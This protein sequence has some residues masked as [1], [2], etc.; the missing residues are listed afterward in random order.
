MWTQGAGEPTALLSRLLE[1]R[2]AIGKFRM[3]LGAGYASTVRPEHADVISFVGLGAV[4]SNAAMCRAGLVDILPCHL[5]EVPVMLRNDTLHVDVV[6]MQLSS[7]KG[8]FSF[9]ATN[10]YVQAALASA[11]VVMA[12]VNDKAPW[13]YS[14]DQFDDSCLSACVPHSQVMMQLPPKAIDD[15]D[16]A[17]AGHIV[18]FIPDG[19]TLQI[20]I[21]TVPNAVFEALR[22]H[23]NLGLHTGVVGDGL[24]DLIESGVVNNSRK[25]VD[26]GRSVTGGLLGT[27]RLYDFAHQN[28]S[29]LVDPVSYT[30]DPGL[31]AKLE[32][33]TAINSAV[34]VDLT[35]QIN[36]EVAAGAYIGTIG[37]QVDFVRGAFASL[38]GRSITGLPSRT[39]KGRA[40]IVSQIA[41]GVVSTA[42]S[43]ADVVVTEFG[44][45]QLRH[46]PI[47][48]RV[49]R[50]IA[51]AHPD[52]RQRLEVEARQL[53]AG[54]R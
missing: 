54:Y 42:R 6:L 49:R 2:H 20:G 11:R 45:A 26:P 27:Q 8:K 31:F 47:P 50:M 28:E 16:R 25:N 10:S 41:S 4:G 40:R 23:H 9:G 43:D 44:S 13:T 3:F 53:V 51:I 19:A 5:S 14:H 1:Q 7:E 22:G 48:E 15:T 35:G 52:D 46:Q 34:E 12:E 39:A 21:G 24:V 29:L 17:I 37:G 18:A 30:H 36:S 32:K 38:G 33:F